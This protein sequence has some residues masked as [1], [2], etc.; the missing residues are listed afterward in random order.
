MEITTI[1]SIDKLDDNAVY[2]D[3]LNGR[4]SP[5]ERLKTMHYFAYEASYTKKDVENA[6]R[7]RVR[8]LINQN[9][10][11]TNKLKQATKMFLLTLNGQPTLYSDLFADEIKKYLE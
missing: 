2:V 8:I 11:F 4:F 1:Q 5:P 6:Y 7:E 3:L 10:E 9:E